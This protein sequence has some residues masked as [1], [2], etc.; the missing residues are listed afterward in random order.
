[1][2]IAM[3]CHMTT[4]FFRCHHT[5]L[6]SSCRC[7]ILYDIISGWVYLLLGEKKSYMAC[8]EELPTQLWVCAGRN[9]TPWG[10]TAAN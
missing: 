10:R 6:I 4:R 5:D 1:M 9:S 7:V 3:T 8:F 2:K